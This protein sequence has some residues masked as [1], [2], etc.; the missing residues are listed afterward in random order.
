MFATLCS[1]FGSQ[2]KSSPRQR[3]VGH[4]RPHL[5]SLEERA[6]PAA[7][8]MSGPP[9]G[10]G[11]NGV[12]PVDLAYL[13]H[14]QQGNEQ[15]IILG[16]TA[17]FLSNN[18]GVRQFGQVLVTDHTQALY[19]DMSILQQAGLPPLIPLG[20]DQLG[21]IQ[22]F[23]SLQGNQ[24][25]LQFALF[26]TVDHMEDLYTGQL[27][28]QFGSYQP[29][30]NDAVQS[31]PMLQKHLSIAESLLTQLSGFNLVGN[32]GNGS[33]SSG[34]NSQQSGSNGNHSGHGQS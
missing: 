2:A 19:Q 22:Q 20:Q 4:S 17:M 6:A 15:E 27:E 9:S 23:Q 3:E 25:N 12:S 30:I 5:E 34:S 18:A 8:T 10:M 32:G 7:M 29:A 11:A 33:N 24:L 14:D 13:V 1:L 16:Y 31:V 28:Q 21:V 26:M